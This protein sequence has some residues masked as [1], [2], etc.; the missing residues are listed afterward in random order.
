[1]AL[2]DRIARILFTDEPRP[3]TPIRLG[4]AVVVTFVLLRF[5]QRVVRWV[6]GYGT[7]ATV[8]VAVGAIRVVL[9]LGLAAL[10]VRLLDRRRLSEYGIRPTT[11]RW[12]RELVVGFG[13]GAGLIAA[14]AAVTLLV[15]WASVAGTFARVPG[16][17]VGSAFP[18]SGA[19]PFWEGLLAMAF[20][21]LAVGITEEVAFRGYLIPNLEAGFAFVSR[22][23]ATPAAV[24]ASSLPFALGHIPN[25]NATVVSTVTTFLAG[26]WLATAYVVTGRLGLP[27]GLHVGWNATMGVGAGLPVSGLVFPAALVN[28]EPTGPAHVTGGSYGPEGGLLGL[29][30]VVLGLVFVWWYATADDS[31]AAR[32]P[33][34]E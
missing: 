10:F 14:L 24:V 1:M 22:R 16:T 30:A 8:I 12:W 28:L 18:I 3:R 6:E 32:G 34:G 4:L 31:S 15:G 5:V 23:Y 17:N 26:V 25:P 2:R 11:G 19:P 13:I 27:I 9:F 20:L 29:A 21:M 7:G 33:L